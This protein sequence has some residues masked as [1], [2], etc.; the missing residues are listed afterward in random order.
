MRRDV[1]EIKGVIVRIELGTASVFCSTSILDIRHFQVR[2][3]ANSLT[4]TS[5]PPA[6][7]L[8]RCNATVCHPC[9][10]RFLSLGTVAN[11]SGTF[12]SV[13]GVNSLG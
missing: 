10:R 13:N 6:Y 12:Q 5:D 11:M 2:Q 3:P 9:R 8:G 7:L 1:D 4:L